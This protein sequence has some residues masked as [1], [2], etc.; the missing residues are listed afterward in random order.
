MSDLHWTG[1]A[2]LLALA[3]LGREATR[4][5]L[6]KSLSWADFAPEHDLDAEPQHTSDEPS[7]LATVRARRGRP[8][9]AQTRQAS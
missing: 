5:R 1:A 3:V 2:V 6:P 7:R 8:R 9:D 4:P